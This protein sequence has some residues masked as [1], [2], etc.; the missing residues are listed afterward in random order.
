MHNI[1]RRLGDIMTKFDYYLYFKHISKYVKMSIICEEIGISR[2]A[3][4]QF[5]KGMYSALS[6]ETC[7]KL[8]AVINNL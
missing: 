8:K 1:P 4:A 3:Y 7:E 5:M 2:N 6:L